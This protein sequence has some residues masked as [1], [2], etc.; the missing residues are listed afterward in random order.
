[1]SHAHA[2]RRAERAQAPPRMR[3]DAILCGEIRRVWGEPFGVYG[4]RKVCKVWRRLG[5]E[6]IGVGRGTVARLMRLM[7]QMGLLGIVR[8]TSVRPMIRDQAGPVRSTGR[9]GHRAGAQRALGPR[10]H[11]CRDPGPAVV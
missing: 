11:L 4:V 2:T 9:G 7:R 6:G 5:R 10:L 1:M 3:R 8:G